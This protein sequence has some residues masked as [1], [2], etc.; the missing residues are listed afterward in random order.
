MNGAKN[1]WQ[2]GHREAIPTCRVGLPSQTAELKNHFARLRPV[3]GSPNQQLQKHI[4]GVALRTLKHL[5][6][7]FEKEESPKTRIRYGPNAIVILNKEDSASKT[8][9]L[10]YLDSSTVTGT[11]FVCPPPHLIHKPHAAVL[12][13]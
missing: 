11:R 12:R 9:E 4:V 8:Y 6:L 13:E 10:R 7:V 5:I 2:G 1:S 3:Y